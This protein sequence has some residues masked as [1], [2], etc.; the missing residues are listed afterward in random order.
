MC[1]LFCGF[2]SRTVARGSVSIAKKGDAVR[3]RRTLTVLRPELFAYAQ[4]LTL[5]ISEAEDL[6]HD[7]VVRALQSGSAGPPSPPPGHSEVAG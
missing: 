4:S 3:L 5:E 1:W 6:V 2:V 7:A